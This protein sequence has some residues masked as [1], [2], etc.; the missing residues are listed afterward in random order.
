M[1]TKTSTS[2]KP[3][4]LPTR[5]FVVPLGFHASSL[6]DEVQIEAIL[7]ASAAIKKVAVKRRNNINIATVTFTVPAGDPVVPRRFEFLDKNEPWN[8][9]PNFREPVGIGSFADCDGYTWWIFEDLNFKSQVQGE[10]LDLDEI[11][12]QSQ[13]RA[14]DQLFGIGI[15]GLHK[16]G[17]RLRVHVSG[18]MQLAIDAVTASGEWGDWEVSYNPK[19]QSIGLV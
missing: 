11:E 7:P 13:V 4:K 19:R 2:P 8:Y 18:F 3:G 5:S 10:E 15:N 9:M 16:T 12:L 1:S 17:Q 6:D 14:L